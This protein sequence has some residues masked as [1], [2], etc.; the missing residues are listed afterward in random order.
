MSIE[1]S[2]PI[3]VGFGGAPAPIPPAPASAK[4]SSVGS[5]SLGFPVLSIIIKSPCATGLLRYAVPRNDLGYVI[6]S[7]S[8]DAAAIPAT[9]AKLLR[10]PNIMKRAMRCHDFRSDQEVRRRQYREYWQ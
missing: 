3:A 1:S 4:R 2:P 10:V 8:K 6:A 5:W 7:G 9:A